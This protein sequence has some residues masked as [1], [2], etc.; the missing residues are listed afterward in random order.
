M[1]HPSDLPQL[2]AALREAGMWRDPLSGG[3]SRE[4]LDFSSNDYL[5]LRYG[6]SSAVSRETAPLSPT[7]GPLD[8]SSVS[9]ET[10]D[11]LVPPPPLPSQPD[12]AFSRDTD[13]SP[14]AAPP[15]PTPVSSAHEPV[16]RSLLA[17]SAVAPPPGG[18]EPAPGESSSLLSPAAAPLIALPS[19]PP[20]S[21]S[22][23][24]GT[25]AS[26][27]SPPP[28]QDA[29]CQEP[30][31]SSS[32]PS[33][34]GVV[35]P[36]APSSPELGSSSGVLFPPE[37]FAA[38]TP[39][40]AGFSSAEPPSPFP[41][42]P[43]SV[44][45]FAA[46]GAGASRLVF[47]TEPAHQAVERELAQFLGTE[48]SLLF[49]SGYAANVGALSALLGPDDL[50]LSDALNHASLIDGIRL[51]KAQVRVFPHLDLD[52]ARELS[53]Q[54]PRPRGATWLVL[55]SY[56]SM[57]GDGP[58]LR[59]ARQLCDERGFAFYVDEAHALGV[60][61]PGGRGRLVES[62]VEADVVLAAFGKAAGSQGAAIGTSRVIR[63]WLWNR[64][65]AFMFSTAPSPLLTET[66]RVQL[67]RLENAEAERAHLEFLGRHFR[68]S[69]QE[70]GVPLTVGSWGPICSVEWGAPDAAV[71][72][73]DQLAIEGYRVQAIRPPTVPEGRSR[74]RITLR[75][76]HTTEQVEQL[77]AILG[78]LWREAEG[79]PWVSSESSSTRGGS[80]EVPLS[81]GSA[82]SR[83]RP[84]RMLVLGTG[85]EIGKTY[86]SCQMVGAL[87][88]AGH[89][90]L[91]LK[92]VES[93][94]RE[95]ATLGDW[96]QLGA[97]GLGPKRPLFALRAPVSPH[98]AARAEGQRIETPLIRAWIEDW[99]R[100]ETPD[101]T[102]IEAAGG[103]F[104]P[105]GDEETNADLLAALEWDLVVL[106]APDRLGVLHDV[107]S[108]LLGLARSVPVRG[109]GVAVV[110]VHGVI[111]SQGRGGVED[112]SFGTN[113]A[114][115]DQMVL[116][117]FQAPNGEQPFLLVCPRG[118][119]PVPGGEAEQSL[120]E[121]LEL[122]LQAGA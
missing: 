27:S 41:S 80:V 45:P 43:F 9:R 100:K 77:A 70:Q 17:S 99:E 2:L 33:S 28:P 110:P 63:E 39:A 95:S 86:T 11:F 23:F 98:L 14:R 117:A 54:A 109:A 19:S 52:R 18:G 89:R 48:S 83:P 36:P 15:R 68:T 61:G 101:F 44:A 55:E 38:R 87:G 20:W 57:D 47:G 74:L 25:A 69:L 13:T 75:A 1:P 26:S 78:R 73:R 7:P 92:P 114:E 82:A 111:L 4:L 29:P 40:S 10:S 8:P 21:A 94:I 34:P 103:A 90:V 49:S 76:A 102:L 116:R 108:C 81:G 60:F 50:V 37:P 65:R 84:R 30:A 115:L 105:L 97:Q 3:P 122:R 5:D 35:L 53:D 66:L 67:R 56:Y 121:W 85:T 79:R 107:R 59:A 64:A 96:Q 12:F 93:G 113:A 119:A 106:V 71:W 120:A 118:G 62:R 46:W 104:S 58:D 42:A 31:S 32:P 22:P 88:R 91:A 24:R 112:A 72:A 51:S 16:P 6:L